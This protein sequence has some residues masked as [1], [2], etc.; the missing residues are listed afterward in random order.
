MIITKRLQ[1]NAGPYQK[2]YFSLDRGDPE[3]AFAG[4]SIVSNPIARPDH[5]RGG[6]RGLEERCLRS[7]REQ[8]FRTRNSGLQIS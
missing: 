2:S 6:R 8:R 1:R 7:D 3:S 4:T 5:Q